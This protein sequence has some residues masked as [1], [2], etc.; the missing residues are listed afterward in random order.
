MIGCDRLEN[1]GRWG[2]IDENRPRISSPVVY[3]MGPD[4]DPDGYADDS[5]PSMAVSPLNVR[6]AEYLNPFIQALPDV[7][8]KVIIFAYYLRKKMP[9]DA[10]YAARRALQDKLDCPP[11]PTAQF[12]RG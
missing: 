10:D 6:D 2:R 5:A 11:T 4:G 12:R 3:D 8:R 7:H 1:W 9:W